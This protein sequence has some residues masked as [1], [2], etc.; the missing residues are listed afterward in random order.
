MPTPLPARTASVAAWPCLSARDDGALLR[1]AVQPGARRTGADGLHD[2]DLRI[3]LVAPPVDG[4]AN[5]ALVAWLA[6]E[7]RCPRRAVRVARGATSRR[8]GLEI[9][10]PPAEVSRW[11]DGL[12]GA[13]R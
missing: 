6:G 13:P 1:V 12:L 9:D 7:L 8:K 3:R 10:L 11:L 5:E 4:K 2:G